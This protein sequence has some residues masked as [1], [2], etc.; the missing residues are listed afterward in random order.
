M[1]LLS[2]Y[3]AFST[4]AGIQSVGVFSPGQGGSTPQPFLPGFFG[5]RLPALGPVPQMSQTLNIPDK[6][7]LCS[8][9][10]PGRVIRLKKHSH[11]APSPSETIRQLKTNSYSYL[12][13][14][15]SDPSG[16]ETLGI[17][18][19]VLKTAVEPWGHET[20]GGLQPTDLAY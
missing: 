2:P 18:D 1:Y 7:F 20:R 5:C 8:C 3:P 13:M 16:S 15:R 10:H 14:I 12:K 4:C 6:W 17:Q 11:F 19:A 9:L